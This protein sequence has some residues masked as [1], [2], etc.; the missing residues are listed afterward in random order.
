[1]IIGS[2][3]EDERGTIP[4][5]GLGTFSVRK[6]AELQLFFGQL[7]QVAILETRCS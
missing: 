1:V 2:P 6:G 4:K 7:I 3:I 5:Y